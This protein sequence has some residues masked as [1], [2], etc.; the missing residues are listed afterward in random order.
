MTAFGKLSKLQCFN[1]V[2]T[3]EKFSFWLA[4]KFSNFWNVKNPFLKYSKYSN[5]PLQTTF[6]LCQHHFSRQHLPIFQNF[7]KDEDLK[8]NEKLWMES[9]NLMKGHW[10]THPLTAGKLHIFYLTFPTAEEAKHRD[11]IRQHHKEWKQNSTGIIPTSYRF[12]TLKIRK[13]GSTYAYTLTRPRL[14]CL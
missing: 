7:W 13:T 8:A 11:I 2:V 14:V 6:L 12:V 9:K 10:L 3:L 4:Q 1:H 5:E